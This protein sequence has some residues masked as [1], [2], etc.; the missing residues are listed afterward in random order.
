MTQS[1]IPGS[2]LGSFTAASVRL[3]GFFGLVIVLA[4]AH[5]IYTA[6]KPDDPFRIP[7]FFHR[8]L[9]RLLGFHIRVHGIMV[10]TPPALFVANHSSYLDITVLG[11]LIPA[12]FVAKAE[13]ARWPMFGWLARMQGTVFIERRTSRIRDHKDS[14]RARFEKKQNLILFP[15]GTSSDGLSVLPFKSGLFGV[16]EENFCNTPVTVQ[17]VSITCTE[18]DGLPITRAWRPYYAWFGDMTLIGHLWNVF[19]L[20]RFTVDVV[21]HP[22]L[23]PHDFADRKALAAACRQ[24]VAR[25]I[26]LCLSGRHLYAEEKLKLSADAPQNAPQMEGL[27]Q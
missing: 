13:V 11:K 7:Q 4:P 26:E 9:V 22:P 1:K 25:G 24:Q 21:F 3:A 2:D 18:L 19:K 14:M 12:A 10:S 15:E 5:L 8:L 23:A 20:G 17:P 27:S 6:F 16:I